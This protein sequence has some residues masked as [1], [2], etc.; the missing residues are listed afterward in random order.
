MGIGR[1][2]FEVNVNERKKDGDIHETALLIQ[3]FIIVS[4]AYCTVTFLG[5]GLP[6]RN[7]EN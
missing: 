1:R 4:K 5:L 6:I 2:R 3:H 7:Q